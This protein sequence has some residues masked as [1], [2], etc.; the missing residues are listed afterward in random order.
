MSSILIAIAVTAA[1]ALA[2]LLSPYPRPP[3]EGK[4]GRLLF[5]SFIRAEI[6]KS[7]AP[8][9]EEARRSGIV[10]D[11]LARAIDRGR[12]LYRE[13]FA[14]DD[15]TAELFEQELQRWLDPG[16]AAPRD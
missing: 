10:G 1:A 5:I 16:G 15:P 8:E 7:F 13:R 12:E 11:R 2:I 14:K 6:E 4:E 3:F 9:L